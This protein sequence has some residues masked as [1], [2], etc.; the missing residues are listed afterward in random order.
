MVIAGA[1]ALTGPGNGPGGGSPQPTGS[2]SGGGASPYDG[3]PAASFAVGA[4]GIA[5]PA[6]RA[7]KN[8]SVDQVSRAQQNVKAALV[9]G[10]LDPRMVVDRQ[11]NGFLALFAEA[12]QGDVRDTFLTG[13]L[14]GA[15][16][17]TAPGTTL[18]AEQPR[19][20]GATTVDASVDDSGLAVLEIDTNYV[21]VYPFTGE[22]KKPG[23]RLVVVHDQLR[24]WVYHRADVKPTSAGLWLNHSAASVTNIDCAYAG[25]QFIAPAP[26]DQKRVAG[27]T[28]DSF[29]PD[30]PVAPVGTC[31]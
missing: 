5:M 4:A 23:D 22:S 27:S 10:H 8:W 14:T 15:A 26:P 1:W 19:V 29:N 11:V 30:N 6:P 25:K 7:V 21:W 17:R 13:P 31:R 20:S 12:D 24:W 28:R 3:T 16:I 18:A 2:A 9:A